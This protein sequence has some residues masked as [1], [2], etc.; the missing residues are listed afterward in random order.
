MTCLW[1]GWSA[2]SKRSSHRRFRKASWPI[3]TN[4]AGR[5]T[6][7][8][9]HHHSPRHHLR[10][11]QRHCGSNPIH[12]LKKRGVRVSRL[13]STVYPPFTMTTTRKTKDRSWILRLSD[14]SPIFP[15]MALLLGGSSSSSSGFSYWPSN[16]W[17]NCRSL[18]CR[19]G[20]L[21]NSW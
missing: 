5:K 19:C 4:V 12:Y 10:C 6:G 3:F 15:I 16:P 2:C 13:P 20:W 14:S 8:Y 17:M 9:R 18:D 7:L 11:F 1:T 21:R